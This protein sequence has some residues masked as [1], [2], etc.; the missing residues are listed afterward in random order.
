MNQMVS[1]FV[2]TAFLAGSMAAGAVTIS[3]SATV[4]TVSPFG[5][6]DTLTY[7]QVFTAPVTGT[8][9]AF[10]LSLNGGVGALF[11]GVGTWN[12][13]ADYGVGFGSPINLYQSVDVPTVVGGAYT[14]TP[15]VEVTAGE[16]YVA[17]L[18]AFDVVGAT[19]TTTMPLGDNSDP[20][21]NYFVWNNATDPRN[22]GAWNYSSNQGEVLFSAT[23]S[24]APALVPEPGTLTLL[25]LGLA[26]FG[27]AR[28]RKL[29]A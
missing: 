11:G 9:D 25:G 19:G 28:S 15:N 18:S 24:R 7:G 6:P 12:G 14:F 26:G 8:L 22:N 5:T 1:A 20:N 21:I 17:Y 4:G 16:L 10:T 29:A 3:N 27:A 2:A 23:F 13:T